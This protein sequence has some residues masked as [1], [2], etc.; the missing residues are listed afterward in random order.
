[1]RDAY[2][3]LAIGDTDR[4]ADSAFRGLESLRSVAATEVFLVS[5][6]VLLIG[7]LLAVVAARSSQTM[8]E[9]REPVHP[10]TILVVAAAVGLLVF[11]LREALDQNFWT[12]PT[13]LIAIAVAGIHGPLSRFLDEAYPERAP[14]A[15]VLVDLVFTTLAI[16]TSAAFPLAMIGGLLA[17]RAYVSRHP[18][19][20]GELVLGLSFGAAIG[21]VGGFDLPTF[22]L[23]AVLLVLPA[24]ALRGPLVR[25]ESAARQGA[26]LPGFLLALPLSALAVAYYYSLSLRLEIQGEELFWIAGVLLVSAATLASLTR[27]V[28]PVG[29]RRGS[30]MAGLALAAVFAGVVLVTRGAVPTFLALLALFT[31]IAYAAIA[32]LDDYAR[33]G[34]DLRRAFSFAVMFLPLFVLFFRIPP[35][36]YSLTGLRVPETIE[37]ALYAPTALIAATCLA[38]TVLIGIRGRLRPEAGKDYP[39][40]AHGGPNTP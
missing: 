24:L 21:F 16:R 31:S 15:A 12:Y 35:I 5:L 6:I 3:Y 18:A 25:R 36:V 17:I 14:I 7:G 30:T 37:L 34:G 38:L 20:S 40:E 29:F 22:T 19:S 8:A 32:G 33:R 23:L 11:A 28:L 2:A 10:G 26:V 13:I 4:A 1:L 39:A 27:R 9:R